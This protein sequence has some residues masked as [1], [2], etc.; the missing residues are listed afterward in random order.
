[1]YAKE[2]SFDTYNGFPM[3]GVHWNHIQSDFLL[4]QMNIPQ[5]L[6]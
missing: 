3:A 2:T 1:M 6:L 5:V 4:S